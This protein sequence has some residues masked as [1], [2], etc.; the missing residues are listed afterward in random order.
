M[1]TL[2]IVIP[3]YNESKTLNTLLDRV[4]RADVGELRKEIVLVDDCSTD[5][6]KEILLAL[7][8]NTDYKVI[9]HDKNKGKG[10]AVI[11][12]F[13]E[14]KGDIIL[15]QD[16]DLEYNP[17]EYENL[18]GPL[19]YG[20]A[21][22][23]YGSRFVGD[24]AHRVL[25][26]W[27]YLG[28]KFLTLLSN[29]FTNLNLT[30]MET[31]YK[32]F[33]KEA[34]KKVLPE[35]RSNR[36]G[37]EP[38]ITALVSHY[39]LR[40]YEVGISY[41][42]RTYEEGK[43]INWKDGVSAVWT[44]LKTRFRLSSFGK[45][46]HKLRALMFSVTVVLLSVF[47]FQPN[48]NGGDTT[49]YVQSMRVISGGQIEAGFMPNRL[50][51]TYL[52]LRVIL[53]VN[54]L[55]NNLLFSWIL[56]NSILFVVMSV[57]FYSLAKRIYEN[58]KVAFWTTVLLAGNY[59]AINFGPSALM[60]VGGWLFYISSV[61][62]SYKYFQSKN[63]NSFWLASFLIAIGGLWKEYTF[64]A[65]VVLFLSYLFNEWRKLKEFIKNMFLAGLIAFTPFALLN[66]YIYLN[67]HYTYAD[68]FAYQTVYVY[69]SRI[70]EYVKAFGSLYNIGWFAFLAGA[71]VFYGKLVT[72]YKNKVMNKETLDYIFILFVLVSVSPF[73][74][75]LAITQRILFI[76]MPGVILITGMYFKKYERQAVYI[77]L[78]L[79][80]YLM[81]SFFM[82]SYILGHINI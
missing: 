43:K 57:V 22:V 40:V 9:F 18:L 60:D 79:I 56:I 1:K 50:V 23:V 81:A 21:D 37:F 73:P 46:R 6:T 3:V 44:I 71:Y 8:K 25:Y 26:F 38:E 14:A 2:S 67:F 16:A 15:I 24:K 64:L 53:L 55:F 72:A 36:F 74:I 76:T 42:G 11:T 62:Y 82:N 31:C 49:T 30:D 68:W 61:Y 35:L 5:G 45:D 12:G 75:W 10:A 69:K 54:G 19:V 27:H 7:S 78:F 52:G 59:A 66:V 17:D 47:F 63:T 77:N 48:L 58:G 4:S 28:N 34:L 41:S 39:G 51:S 32:V 13:K 80:L 29:L 65:F 33:T 70:V 20:N